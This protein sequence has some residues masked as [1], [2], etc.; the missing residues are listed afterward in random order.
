MNDLIH[1]MNVTKIV[2]KKG[3]SNKLSINTPKNVMSLL[4]IL[5]LT[6]ANFQHT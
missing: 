4:C 6:L 5:Y 2:C 3:S 1:I